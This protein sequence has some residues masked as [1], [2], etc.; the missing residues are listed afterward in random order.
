MKVKMAQSCPTLCDPMDCSPL[1]SSVRGILQA[2]ILEGVAMPSSKGLPD[3][4]IELAFTTAYNIDNKDLLHSTGN[5]TQSSVMAY[6]ERNLKTSGYVT[7]Y[8]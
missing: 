8:N 1:G 2:R 5:S 3:P 7:V 4:G 6:V